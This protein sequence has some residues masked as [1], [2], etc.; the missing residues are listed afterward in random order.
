MHYL[1]VGSL[2]SPIPLDT[3]STNETH[4]K[5]NFDDWYI[6]SSIVTIV[7]GLLLFIRFVYF[8]SVAAPR[9]WIWAGGFIFVYSGSARLISFEINLISKETSRA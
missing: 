6:I 2:I 5:K 1:L 4:E 8:Y 3:L 9:T 7:I